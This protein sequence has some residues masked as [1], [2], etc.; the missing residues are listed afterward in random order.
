MTDEEIFEQ[1]EKY[2]D[3]DDF[4]RWTFRD[5]DGLLRFVD[6]IVRTHTPEDIKKI[7]RKWDVKPS[8]YD[9]VGRL[10]KSGKG[11]Y[12]DGT[13]IDYKEIQLKTE[14]VSEDVFECVE[15]R[16]PR[17]PQRQWV[18][19]DDDIPGLGLVTEEFYNGM[20]FAEDILR[21]KNT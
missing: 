18:G 21:E 17:P 9:D 14:S 19:L 5:N 2:G 6:S 15:V 8:F 13:P 12:D 4:G 11:F 1:A 3:W 7:E 20:I 16:I 10:L